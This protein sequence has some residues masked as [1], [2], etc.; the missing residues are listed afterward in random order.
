MEE[1]I[2]SNIDCKEKPLS[3]LI[4]V[5]ASFTASSGDDNP[6]IVNSHFWSKSYRKR[7]NIYVVDFK[8]YLYIDKR[9]PLLLLLK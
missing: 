4:T 6:K 2:S 7:L 1:T 3:V 8:V 9:F 5:D